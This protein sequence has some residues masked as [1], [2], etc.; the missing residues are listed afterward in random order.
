MYGIYC[1]LAERCNCIASSAIA[2]RCFLSV[3]YRVCR[4]KTAEIRIMQFSLKC[5][6]L[7]RLCD[8]V[9]HQR[10][11]PVL[12]AKFDDEIRRESPRSLI[13][14]TGVGWFSIDFATL[15]GKRTHRREIELK[16]IN[17]Y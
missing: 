5:I 3:E 1:I 13:A 11:P 17:H 14:Q 2:I 15:S 8:G 6:R 16:C 12:T 7:P 4:D 10:T 9:L